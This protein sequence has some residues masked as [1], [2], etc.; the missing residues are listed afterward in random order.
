MA[1]QAHSLARGPP[2]AAFGAMHT[3]KMSV[4]LGKQLKQGGVEALAIC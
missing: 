4:S 2:N 1:V 3:G